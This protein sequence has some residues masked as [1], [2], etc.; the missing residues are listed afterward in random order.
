MIYSPVIRCGL[1]QTI[2]V[3]WYN[4]KITSVLYKYLQHVYKHQQSDEKAYTNIVFFVERAQGSK[5][6]W[7]CR[8]EIGKLYSVGLD[9]HIL[10]Y[11]KARCDGFSINL[12]NDTCWVP[13]FVGAG[14]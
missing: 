9:I 13:R 10:V 12:T 6:F 1:I 3:Y 5:E 8:S 7:V 11:Q 2:S 14:H 4:L